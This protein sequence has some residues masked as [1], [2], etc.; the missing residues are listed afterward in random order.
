MSRLGEVARVFTKLGFTAFGGPAAHIAMMEEQTVQRRHWLDRQHFLDVVAAVNLIPGPGSTQLAIQLGFLRAGYPGLFVAG[1]CFIIPAM[2]I[3]LPIAWLYVTYGQA[4][5][6]QDVLVG[7]NACVVAIIAAAV[8]R[9]ARTG[10]KDRFG[11]VIAILSVIAGF[12]ADPKL[13][14]WMGNHHSTLAPLLAGWSRGHAD[15]I[16]LAL[17]AVAGIAWYARPKSVPVIPPAAAHGIGSRSWVV[18]QND[19]AV[20]QGR[21]DSFREW[22]CA[23]QL[24][25]GL[26]RRRAWVD[27]PEAVARC[28]R[29]RAGDPRPA[30]DPQPRSPGSSSG[31][32]A[33]AAVCLAGF[34]AAY[35]RRSPSSY[36]H[37]S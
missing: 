36:R 17:A 34:S 11:C 32:L 15:L 9:F 22:I 33:S 2:L 23:G 19:V 12:A 8:L 31:T 5:Q 7:I 28:H 24:L 25:A 37:L 10:I 21:R 4:P 14:R 16:I 27:D 18:S 1:L 6:F 13:A 20:S 26:D 30:S 35:S 29:C 3:I